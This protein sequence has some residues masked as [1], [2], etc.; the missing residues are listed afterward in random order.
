MGYRKNPETDQRASRDRDEEEVIRVEVPYLRIIDEDLW[1]AV[2]ARQEGQRRTLAE[3][4]PSTLRRKRYLLSGLVRCGQCGGNM[5]VA[6]SGRSRAYY[7]A[8]AKEKGPSVCGGIGVPPLK[9]S[10]F[11]DRI[12]PFSGGRR[13]GW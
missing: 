13:D 7:C 1:R 9:W 5:T 8:N 4:A 11:W 3:A 6:G 2:K 12:I 10:T